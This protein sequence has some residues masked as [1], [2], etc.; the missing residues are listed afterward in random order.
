MHRNMKQLTI[1][2]V[3]L[4][5]SSFFGFSQIWVQPNAVWHYD[6]WTIG[7]GGF[8]KIEHIGDSVIQGKSTMVIESKDYRFFS[9]QFGQVSSSGPYVMDTN[10]IYAEG[11]TVFYWQNNQFQKMLDF[12][13]IIGESYFI[14]ETAGNNMC[15]DSSYTEVIGT[16]TDALGFEFVELNSPDTSEIRLFGQYNTRFGG[17]QFL[18]PRDFLTCDPQ[19]IED[20]YMFTFKCFQDD[21]MFYNPSGE[22]CEYLLTHLG[23]TENE[24]PKIRI[25]PNPADQTLSF[26]AKEKIESISIMD[27][28][29]RIILNENSIENNSVNIENLPN[30]IYLI[31]LIDNNGSQT[32]QRFTKN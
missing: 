30:G 11:D 13:K 16:G 3:I 8:V 32:I 26:D 22:D 29:G 19:H 1:L 25:Y 20:Y 15:S 14:G 18:F 24:L 21:G 27:I 4:S 5:M 10:Y 7:W 9:D 28:K 2:F 6:Y 12:S 17:G 23:I 31:L